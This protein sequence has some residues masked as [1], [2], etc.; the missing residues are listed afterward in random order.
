[1]SIC[2]EPQ[3]LSQVVMWTI[4]RSTPRT[5]RSILSS[6]CSP[7]FWIITTECMYKVRGQ[8]FLTLELGQN[9]VNMAWFNNGHFSLQNSSPNAGPTREGGRRES[10]NSFWLDLAKIALAAALAVAAEVLAREVLDRKKR[11]EA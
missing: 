3:L 7:V 2:S 4:V 11:R 5:P 10:M 8:K 1:M 6:E 9:A